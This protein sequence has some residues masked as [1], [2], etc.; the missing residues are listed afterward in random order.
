MSGSIRLFVYVRRRMA[1][2]AS[3]QK[4]GAALTRRQQTRGPTAHDTLCRAARGNPMPTNHHRY[5]RTGLTAV[6][7]VL[8]GGCS[9]SSGSAD[10][11]NVAPPAPD[12][13]KTVNLMT[14]QELSSLPTQPPDQRISYG[15]D[16]SQY[17]ELRVPTGPGSHPVVVLVHGGCFKAAYAQASYFGQVGDALKAKGIATW[18]IEYRRLGQPGS[19]WPGTYLD[20]AHG[21]DHLRAIAAQ[22]K[23]D[24]RRV[25]IVGHSAGGHLAIWAAAR[26]RVPKGS[27]LYLA[28]PLPVR[29]V[30]DL[31]G[32]VDMTA[33]IREY[34]GLCQDSV[35]TTLLGGT[36]STV[37]DR[38]AQASPMALLPLGVPQVIVIGTHEDYVPRD[39]V[40]AY[41]SAAAKAGDSVRTIIFP[42]A[43]HFEIASASQWTWPRI[44]TAIRALLDGKLPPE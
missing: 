40:D 37:P 19:G 44:E 20:V 29:G 38:Y 43:G 26:T 34:E 33:H 25:V 21:V 16:S 23:L 36:P 39:L 1:Y 17:G 24:L 13:A 27:P 28:N 15:T 42:G 8:S 6:L 9:R 14:P 41:A 30:V 7:L 22:H 35:I 32:P 11:S 10:T 4:H 3:V 31:A 5:R 2:V 18:N 12:T